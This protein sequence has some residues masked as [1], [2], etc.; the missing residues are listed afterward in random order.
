[1]SNQTVEFDQETCLKIERA[2]H[3]ILHGFCSRVEV[4]K[5]VKVYACKNVIRID[6]KVVDQELGG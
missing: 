5:N 6:L 1:M 3:D 2:I 4:G